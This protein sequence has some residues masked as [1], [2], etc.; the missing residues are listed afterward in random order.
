MKKT[1]GSFNPDGGVHLLRAVNY[2]ELARMDE[3]TPDGRLLVATGGS[4]RT[5]PVAIMAQ[6]ETAPVV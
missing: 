2:P 1:L 5:L 6:F 3:A 4:T